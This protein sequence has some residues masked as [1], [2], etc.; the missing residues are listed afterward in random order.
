[1]EKPYIKTIDEMT[2]E[3]ISKIHRSLFENDEDTPIY[4]SY[5]PEVKTM[6]YVGKIAR[7]TGRWGLM[8]PAVIVGSAG[9]GIWRATKKLAKGTVA[10]SAVAAVTV[11]QSATEI[12]NTPIQSAKEF[13]KE[14]QDN[15]E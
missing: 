10:T 13:L 5:Q 12:V 11:A 3:E 14:H 2:P 4:N 1:M 6:Y 7:K 9:Y 15:N 8:F